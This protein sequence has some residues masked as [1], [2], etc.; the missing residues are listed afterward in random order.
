MP[1]SGLQVWWKPGIVFATLFSVMMI[2][3]ALNRIKLEAFEDEKG[4][5]K[6]NWMIDV[7]IE[8]S[9]VF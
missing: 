7:K 1:G 4:K 6:Q 3:I 9:C 2:G 8:N 5:S